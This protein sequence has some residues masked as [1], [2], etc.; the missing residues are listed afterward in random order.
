MRETGLLVG[1]SWR[2]SGQAL[3]VTDRWSAAPCGEVQL[4]RPEDVDAAVQSAFAQAA[5]WR[6]D[7]PA[8]TER[9]RWLERAAQIVHDRQEPLRDAVVAETGFTV[10]DAATEV[11]R[12]VGTLRASAAEAL[13]IGGEV[14]PV[15]AHPRSADRVAFTQRFPV[16]VVCAVSPFNSPLNTVC[17][18][19]GPA[20]A[21][22]N[23]VVLKPSMLTALCATR[24]MTCLLDAGVPPGALGLVVGSG[25]S[26]GEQLLGDR[27]IGF[28]TFTGS[29]AAGQRVKAASGLARVHL[30]LG[31]NS[32]TIVLEDA[33]LDLVVDLVARAG[34]RKAGQVCTSVQRLVVHTRV[35]DR[36][37]ELLARRVRLLRVGDPHLPETEV[38]PM[39]REQAAGRVADWV[40]QARTQGARILAGGDRQGALMQPTLLDAV[41]EGM[42]IA[43]DEAFGPVVGIMRVGSLEEAIAVA[44]ATVYGLQAG[45]FTRDVDAAFFAAR[46]LQFG[47]V[48]V[49]DTS[50]YHADV[51]P[52]G[53]V[54]DS[55]FG[56][57]GP[58]YAIEE[59]SVPRI[60]VFN[61]RRPDTR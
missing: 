21:A 9:A 14:V 7:P 41:T 25:E 45:I 27:R 40:A 2:R 51:M 4:A 22:G 5:R 50:S 44:N 39:I 37:S 31:A 61:L 20:L 60:V 26:V 35:A 30:E 42:R 54:K 17:H 24:L 8:P 12:A 18:K 29:T 36:L 43:V 23:A 57:E 52:Y 13:R 58:R 11:A 59:M 28:Y 49:N 1:G 53:G 33:D 32:P 48:M 19:I 47:G 34:F 15:A 38:G 46:K 56:L 3:A 55:G 10:T 16:G 6:E